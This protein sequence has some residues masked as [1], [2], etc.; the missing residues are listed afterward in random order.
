[1]PSSPPTALK[2]S[3]VYERKDAPH[4]VGIKLPIAEP[5]VIP[6]ITNDLVDIYSVYD[7]YIVYNMQIYLL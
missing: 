3:D 5:T 2:M 7:I 1:M 6:N 4:K